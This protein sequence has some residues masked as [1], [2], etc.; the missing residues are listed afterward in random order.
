M[1]GVIQST[2]QLNGGHLDYDCASLWL[3][4][5][6]RLMIV[7]ESNVMFTGGTQRIIYP[8][9]TRAARPRHGTLRKH[10]ISILRSPPPG[11]IIFS[12]EAKLGER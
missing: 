4:L 9:R 8:N 7:A 1:K 10:Q 6:Q 3:R 11:Y 2:E 12:G 5:W